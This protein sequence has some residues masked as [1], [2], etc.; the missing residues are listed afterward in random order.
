MPKISVWFIRIALIWLVI[1]AIAGAMML[2]TKAT[3]WQPRMWQ[4][5]MPHIEAGLVGWFLLLI[6]GVAWYMLPRRITHDHPRGH[7]AL[8][9][10]SLILINLGMIL[11]M[12]LPPGTFGAI[13]GTIF[14]VVAI[15]CFVIAIW[16]R[17]A[18]TEML[19]GK[20]GKGKVTK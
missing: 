18:S 14:Y 17:V 7:P 13:S 8:A 16:P 10:S 19:F 5:R 20:R 3:G 15:I 12:I 6:K 1:T 9:W 11:T 4:M 2:T